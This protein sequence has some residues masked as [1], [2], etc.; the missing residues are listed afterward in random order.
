MFLPS[1]VLKKVKRENA[2]LSTRII[3]QTNS[4]KLSETNMAGI[5]LGT[6]I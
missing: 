2:T 4:G 5:F 6:D 1:L 3:S